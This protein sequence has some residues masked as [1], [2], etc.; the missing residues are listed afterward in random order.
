MVPYACLGI[1]QNLPTLCKAAT[2]LEREREVEGSGLGSE[3]RRPSSVVKA[4]TFKASLSL[5]QSQMRMG[6]ALELRNK[7]GSGPQNLT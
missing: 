6:K 1:I 7:D 5:S 3:G 4:K 2:D